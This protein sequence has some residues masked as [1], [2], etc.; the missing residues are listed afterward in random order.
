MTGLQLVAH[1]CSLALAVVTD[2]AVAIRLVRA[3]QALL[4]APNVF[5]LLASYGERRIVDD[6]GFSGNDNWPLA[7]EYM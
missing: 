4:P 6:H 5:P 1:V 3:P 2:E 7:A